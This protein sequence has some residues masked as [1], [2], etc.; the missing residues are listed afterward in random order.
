[1]LTRVLDIHTL[2]RYN[3]LHATDKFGDTHVIIFQAM[4]LNT[5]KSPFISDI[6]FSH[7]SFKLDMH[8]VF[9]LSQF[10]LQF[11]WI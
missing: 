10:Q 3:C 9:N 4:L 5:D 11:I 8:F 6:V 7:P 2:C 1:M